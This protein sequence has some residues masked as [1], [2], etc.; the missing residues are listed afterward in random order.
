MWR[1]GAPLLRA[2]QGAPGAKGSQDNPC[3]CICRVGLPGRLL[4]LV[5]VRPSTLLIKL[6]WQWAPWLSVCGARPSSCTGNKPS[7]PRVSVSFL[8]GPTGP[9]PSQLQ[10]PRLHLSWKTAGLMHLTRVARGLQALT[11]LPL[12]FPGP[13]WGLPGGSG[14]SPAG[15]PCPASTG[16]KP[17]KQTM[18]TCPRDRA[19]GR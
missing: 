5:K 11:S 2:P 9:R 10:S 6:S 8:S 13:A 15:S 3:L 4:P 16:T 7:I 14:N 17:G 12:E 19:G 1:D 18:G